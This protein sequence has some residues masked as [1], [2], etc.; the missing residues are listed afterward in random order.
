MEPTMVSKFLGNYV[1]VQHSILILLSNFILFSLYLK[2]ICS[3]VVPLEGG[4]I[5]D[6]EGNNIWVSNKKIL[7]KLFFKLL[8]NS[9]FKI[10]I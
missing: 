4:K 3:Q 2:N 8:I 1:N 7:L 6:A 10:G 5:L 9:Y